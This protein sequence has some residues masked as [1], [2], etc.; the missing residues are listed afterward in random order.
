VS[1]EPSVVITEEYDVT[2]GSEDW[3]KKCINDQHLYI[4]FIDVLD[5]PKHVTVYG[6][7]KYINKLKVYLFGS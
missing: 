7:I 1:L 4:N 5:W 2:V 3:C 6:I